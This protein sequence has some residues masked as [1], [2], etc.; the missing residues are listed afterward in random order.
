MRRIWLLLALL[1]LSGCAGQNRD[2]RNGPVHITY[3]EKWTGFEGDAMRATVDAFNRS[4]D[5]IHVDLLTV[6]QVDQKML[7]ATAGGIPPDVAGLWSYNTN[8]YADKNAIIPL[9]SFMKEAGIKQEDYIRSYWDLGFY[10]SKT[11][12]LPTTPATCALHWNKDMFRRAGLDPERPPR[13]IEELDA[14]A[15]KLTIR[16]EKG[17]IQQIGF[18]PAEPGWWNWGW[19][20]FFG[21]RLWD[22]ESKITADCPENIRAFQWVQSYAKAYGVQDLQVFQSGFGN[23][24]SPQNAFL[25][26]KVAM[27]LQGVW[28]YNF[29]NKFAP[30]LKWGAAPFPYPSDRPDLANSSPVD[31]DI[32]VIPNG[33][34]HPREAFEFI[35]FVQSQKGMELLCMGQRKQTPLTKA[36]REFL[37][38]HPHPFIETFIELGKTRNA[39]ATPK[40]G[41][42]REYQDELQNAFSNIWLCKMTPEEALRAVQTRMQKKLDR[43]IRQKARLGRNP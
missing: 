38:T 32:L 19:G 26:G 29:I 22:G 39:F 42:W 5:R 41:I 16:D 23:F 36:S 6:S 10:R 8:V 12:A 17:R 27:E 9:D 1:V 24:S 21:G 4:Q 7:L 14:Y 2:L 33:A 43:E 13:T 35:K 3:W 40:I 25:A 18:M 11:W 28:M 37:K 30:H 20:F 31:E 15:R 34:R